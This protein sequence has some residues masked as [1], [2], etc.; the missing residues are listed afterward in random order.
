MTGDEGLRGLATALEHSFQVAAGLYGVLVQAPRQ[1]QQGRR[2]QGVQPI[3]RVPQSGGDR[4]GDIVRRARSAAAEKM[5]D[6]DVGALGIDLGH[7][8]DE[9][10]DPHRL[11][12]ASV[13]GI[14]SQ[15]DEG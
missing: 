5:A 12:I 13:G 4:P 9:P 2:G 14:D 7:S 6:Q 11:S 8:G 1:H 3:G 15:T 10:P